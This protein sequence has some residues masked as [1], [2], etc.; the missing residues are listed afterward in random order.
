MQLNPLAFN[1][2][3]FFFKIIRAKTAAT[4]HRMFTEG[5]GRGKKGE[6]GTE[7]RLKTQTGRE[8]ISSD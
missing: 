7:P 4:R 1:N 5:T 8:K 3:F 2:F 6:R